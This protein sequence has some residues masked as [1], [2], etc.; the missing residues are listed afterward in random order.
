MMA[1]S[2]F[3]M[4]RWATSD[5]HN[6][7]P[8]PPWSWP[9]ISWTHGQP[10]LLL[11]SQLTPFNT[12]A[13]TSKSLEDPSFWPKS[14]QTS[15]PSPHLSYHTS[16]SH[17]RANNAILKPLLILQF[18]FQQ[19]FL[20]RLTFIW[21]YPLRIILS[22]TYRWQGI[23][24]RWEMEQTWLREWLVSV[25]LTLPVPECVPKLIQ[26]CTLFSSWKMRS[27]LSWLIPNQRSVSTWFMM[28][29]LSP[30]M[31]RSHFL[32]GYQTQ[33]P[34]LPSNEAQ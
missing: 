23:K 21:L 17:K 4:W 24:P 1:R 29:S 30:A 20:H 6:S 25:R 15:L 14:T 10:T 26:P 13:S 34:E 22:G 33:S 5:S 9:F 7:R 11:R 16:P 18:R 31:S 32:I 3:S 28:V 19:Q 8:V 27:I 12:I 2:G